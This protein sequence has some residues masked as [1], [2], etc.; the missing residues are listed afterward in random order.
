MDS[1]SFLRKQESDTDSHRLLHT[2]SADRKVCELIENLIRSAKI[3][4]SGFLHPPGMK[5]QKIAPRYFCTP[6]L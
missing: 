3:K 2:A 6:D 4:R 1:M 5:A